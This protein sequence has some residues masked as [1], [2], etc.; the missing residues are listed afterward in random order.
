MLA[1]WFY[2]NLLRPLLFTV[3]AEEAHNLASRLIPAATGLL[4]V[5]QAE[6]FSDEVLAAMPRL[7][8]QIAGN[9]L[10]HPIG[11]AAGFDKNA[12]LLPFLHEFGFAFAEIGSVTASQSDGNARPRLFRLPADEAIINRMGLNGEGAS[13]VFA[14]LTA[15]QKGDSVKLPVALNI[16]KS[17]LPGLSGDDATRDILFTF[18][19][20]KHAQLAYV[21]INTSCPNT[22][23]GALNEAAHL[24][25]I[26]ATVTGAN[27]E[28]KALFLK[29]SPD[30]PDDFIDM[31][32]ALAGEFGVAGFVCGN[33]SI[34]RDNLAESAAR[35][36]AAGPG[37]LSGAPLRA[38][39]LAQVARIYKTKSA[40]QQ[41]IACG[42]IS[43]AYDVV[44]AIASGACAVQI[45][46]ALVYEGPFV[47][48]ETVA[49]LA[50]ALAKEKTTLTEL[51]GNDKLANALLDRIP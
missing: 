34:K 2:K 43:D 17:N 47:V 21:T 9:P 38:A 49:S 48:M 26:L 29:L 18:N 4:K 51:I 1:T 50:L 11:V 6:V 45:Y 28:G 44:A 10:S 20:F 3:D 23:E 24:R 42:G 25:E 31:V 33:T 46:T 19:Q 32:V 5:A 37:G 27:S 41:I 36:A 30:S 7:Q 35:V 40:S 8:G 13:A 39:M 14:R 22:H 16:A 12:R 15:M